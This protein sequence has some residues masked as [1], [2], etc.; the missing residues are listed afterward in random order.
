MIVIDRMA[1]EEKRGEMREE[2]AARMG[3]VQLGCIPTSNDGIAE[4]ALLYR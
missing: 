1:W 3:D 2:I 4:E